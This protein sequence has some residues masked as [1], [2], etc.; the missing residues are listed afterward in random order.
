[1]IAFLI[2]WLFCGN[3]MK[4]DFLISL[5]SFAIYILIL[6][7]MALIRT[8]FYDTIKSFIVFLQ[9]GIKNNWIRFQITIIIT[10]IVLLYLL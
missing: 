2:G 8:M 3:V 7:M 6:Y 9:Y 4:P 1:M 5:S 10:T